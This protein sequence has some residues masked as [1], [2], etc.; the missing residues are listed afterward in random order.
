MNRWYRLTCYPSY[1]RARTCCASLVE[2]RTSVVTPVR[3]MYLLPW[4]TTRTCHSCRLFYGLLCVSSQRS[5]T[6]RESVCIVLC[7]HLTV[8]SVPYAQEHKD[9]TNTVFKFYYHG[10]IPLPLF[11]PGLALFCLFAFVLSLSFQSCAAI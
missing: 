5:D 4:Y 10:T 6:R 3:D 9:F 1:P 2:R 8:P 7:Y 11:V